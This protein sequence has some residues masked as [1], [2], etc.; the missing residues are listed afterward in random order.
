MEKLQ[1]YKTRVSLNFEVYS[2]S[3]FNLILFMM[4]ISIRTFFLSVFSSFYLC[5][6]SQ[7]KSFILFAGVS[8]PTWGLPVEGR[9]SCS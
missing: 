5:I 9:E 3:S 1:S 2:L 4:L 7:L 6:Y 8:I